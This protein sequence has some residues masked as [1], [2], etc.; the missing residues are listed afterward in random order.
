MA[1]T[2]RE[3]V[4]AIQASVDADVA[5]WTLVLVVLLVIG[6]AVAIL[7]TT[8]I[9]RSIMRPLGAIDAALGRLASG[10][11]SSRVTITGDDE[12]AASGS[13]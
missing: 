7:I 12:L 13:A 3:R 9:V 5:R 6:V 2:S 10:D 1:S 4:I 11:L 8:R